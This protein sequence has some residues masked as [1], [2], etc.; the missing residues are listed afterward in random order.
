MGSVSDFPERKE[1]EG[2]LRLL[3]ATRNVQI[4]S[5]AR[6]IFRLL[7]DTE[8]SLEPSA[9]ARSEAK[10]V[11]AEAVLRI[12]GLEPSG[13]PTKEWMR[14]ATELEQEFTGGPR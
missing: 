4:E 13:M 8:R 9:S 5:L 2:D 3:I 14:R 12:R 10:F 11:A 1:T 6:T 7:R